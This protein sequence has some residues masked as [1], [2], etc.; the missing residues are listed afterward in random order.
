MATLV[1]NHGWYYAQ[2]YDGARKPKRKRVPLKT[3]TKREAKKM[4]R[5]LE[6]EYASRDYDPWTGYRANQST[7]PIDE[8]ATVDEALDY[9]IEKKSKEDWRENTTVNNTYVLKAFARFVG[10][11]NS[12]RALTSAKVNAYL[13]QDRFA[14]ETKKTHKKRVMGFLNWLHQEKIVSNDFSGVKIYNNDNEQDQSVS[15]VSP[16]EI[17]TIKDTI[18]EK[19]HSDIEQGYQTEKRNALWLVDFVDWQWYSGMRISESLNLYPDDINTDTWEV[20]IGSDTFSTKTKSK[21]ILPIGDVEVLKKIAKKRLDKVDQNERLFQHKD[22]RRTTRTFKKYVKLA[23]PDRKDINMHTLRHSCC[24]EL[25]RQGVPIYTV[26]RWMR[27]SSVK[28]TQRY[29]DLLATDISEA[30]GEAF[31]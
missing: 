1:K 27:H 28:T 4:L 9:F 12:V 30:V 6:D 31:R 16:D 13:N 2:F 18:R 20:K 11:D 25:L 15:Y 8:N 29:A 14:Y 23:L 24:I 5:Q 21:Q 26:Q 19:V 22:R 7:I 3:R 10:D 17:K